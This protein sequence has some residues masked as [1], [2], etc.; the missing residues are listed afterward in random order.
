MA[1]TIMDTTT[2]RATITVVDIIIMDTTMILDTHHIITL[3]ERN[4]D[5]LYFGM[6][7]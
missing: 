6:F 4:N 1:P 2:I 3:T 7:Y 5:L